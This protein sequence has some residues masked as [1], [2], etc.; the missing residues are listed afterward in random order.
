MEEELEGETSALT[1]HDRPSHKSAEP[2]P[3]PVQGTTPGSEPGR[4]TATSV[5]SPLEALAHAEIEGTRRF[6]YVGTA[7]AIVGAAAAL[8][9]PGQPIPTRILLV[10]IAFGIAGMLYLL[11]RT[12]DPATYHDG[13]GTA[14][15]WYIPAIGVCA[16]IPFFGAFSPA[17]VLLVLGIYFISTGSNFALATAM[18]LT[19]ASVQAVTSGLVIARVISEPG[20]IGAGP[21]GTRDQIIAQTLVQVVL[22]GTFM[23]ARASRKSSLAALDELERAVRAVAQREALLEEAREEL[24]RAV[25][26]GRGRFTDQTIGHY[27]LGDVIGRGAMGE[28]YEGV[29]ARTGHPVAVKLLSHASLGNAQHVERF[30]RELRTAATIDSPNVVRVLEV[31]EMPLPYLVM[32]R[33]RGRDL[34][35]ILRSEDADGSTIACSI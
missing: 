15:G 14:I 6:A 26:S 18:Y 34:G 3:P 23:I 28:V 21:L 2:P 22:L 19:C 16:A 10:S 7:L 32:E 1:E 4:S 30:L 35:A 8:V 20:I 31:G 24:R 17:P 29:D 27:K 13:I 11:H 5:A 12:R 33:L 9:L 25:G